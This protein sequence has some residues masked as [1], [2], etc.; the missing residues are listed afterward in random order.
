MKLYTRHQLS[1]FL[2]ANGDGGITFA[3]DGDIDTMG[4]DSDDIDPFR[5]VSREACK[6]AKSK[7]GRPPSSP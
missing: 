2:G 5:L 3:C 4:V 6:A 7:L 1:V